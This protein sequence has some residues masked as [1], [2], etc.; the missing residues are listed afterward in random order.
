MRSPSRSPNRTDGLAARQ[1]GFSLFE[2]L[3]AIGLAAVLLAVFTAILAATVFLRRSQYNIQAANFIQEELDSLRTL[4][5]TELLDRTNGRFL[6]LAI[7]RGPWVVKSDAGA[8]PPSSPKVVAME[9]AQAAVIE[10]TGL[11]MLPGNHRGDATVA[12]KVRILSSSPAGWAAGIAFRYRDAENHYR[13]RLTSGGAALDR[14]AQ[15]VKTTLWSDSNPNSTNTWYTLEVV[16]AGNSFTLKSNGATLTTRTDNS[17][18]M[19][20]LAIISLNSALLYCDDVAVTE[21]STTTYAF[22]AYADG[23]LP[24]NWQRLSYLDLPNGNGTVTIANYLGEANMKK[25]DVRIS[26]IDTGITRSVT[27]STIIAK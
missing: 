25:I 11:L 19:G 8:S 13:F 4:P 12:A 22:D 27:G 7:M 24:A 20:G 6:G 18:A 14:I 23:A 2:A 26:W 10:E 1:A 5:Y 21:G 17:F 15:G 9:T 16:M 3:I